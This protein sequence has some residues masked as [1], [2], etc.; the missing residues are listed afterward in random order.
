MESKLKVANWL[1]HDTRR[2]R[3]ANDESTTFNIP[4]DGSNKCVVKTAQAR[5]KLQKIV[6]NIGPYEC[7]L[8]K[9]VYEDAFELAMHNCPR[10]VH[11]EYK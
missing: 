9:H 10:V 6:N 1:I 8:C 4:K 2:K 7:K 11:L 3:K 5:A